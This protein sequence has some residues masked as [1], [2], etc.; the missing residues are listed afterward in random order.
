MRNRS[1]KKDLFKGRHF[2]QEIMIPRALVPALQAIVPRLGRDDG[3]ARPVRRAYDDPALGTALRARVRQALEPLFSSGRQLM[4]REETYVGIR[5]KWA[6]LYRAV[7][8]AG[9]TVDFRL[10]LRRDAASANAFFRKAVHSQGQSPSTV[11][12]NGMRR[13]KVQFANLKQKGALAELTTLRSSKY[14]NNPIEQD[15]RNIKSRLSV[16]LG[17]K[18]FA[19]AAITIR[20][21]G[22]MHRIRKGQFDL[23]AL[24]TQ[25]KTPSEISAAV[26]AA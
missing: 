7:Y 11:T 24:A 23:R 12:L 3:R 5:G 9:K 15:H 4:A 21:A 26:L 10:T 16:M 18:S 2:E 8:S 25:G 6:D 14:L 1:S 17:L 20:G 22:L 19:S 13:R